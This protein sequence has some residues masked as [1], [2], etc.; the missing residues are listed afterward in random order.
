MAQR[1]F[2][3]SSVVEV[4]SDIPLFNKNYETSYTQPKPQLSMLRNIFINNPQK[5]YY[6]KYSKPP[7]APKLTFAKKPFPIDGIMENT[8]QVEVFD[9]QLS[10]STVTQFMP[11]KNDIQNSISTKPSASNLMIDL[12]DYDFKNDQLITPSYVFDNSI[13]KPYKK[14]FTEKYNFKKSDFASNSKSV[15]VPEAQPL[16][17][18]NEKLLTVDYD[19]FVFKQPNLSMFTNSNLNKIAKLP[20]INSIS[21][22]V[23]SDALTD[24]ILQPNDHAILPSN[25][26]KTFSKEFNF[27]KKTNSWDN[28]NNLNIL[29]ANED[30]VFESNTQNHISSWVDLNV[31]DNTK[32]SKNV[33]KK[34]KEIDFNDNFEKNKK[35]VD[36]SQSQS[37]QKLK[38]MF[39]IDDILNENINQT[40]SSLTESLSS[41]FSWPVK[42]LPIVKPATTV[43]PITNLNNE[44]TSE[45]NNP[46]INNSISIN[47]VKDYFLSTDNNLNVT[48]TNSLTIDGN[49]KNINNF[50]TS[51]LNNQKILDNQ[52]KIQNFLSNV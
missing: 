40:I 25:Q 36:S 51:E 44:N 16:L 11:T 45:K 9:S 13:T 48:Q 26:N 3:T 47:P 32:S 8:Q 18:N 41:I 50:T 34:D 29:T 27:F 7:S 10:S 35:V 43:I 15:V 17:I 12:I 49:N 1:I 52:N 42:A 46:V 6:E 31:A 22:V 39:F 14:V 33:K 30:D 23:D 20:Q 37:E 5:Q 21:V 19:N 38:N 28:K 24:T 4:P 2:S